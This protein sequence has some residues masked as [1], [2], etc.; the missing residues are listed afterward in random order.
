MRTIKTGVLYL[1]DR[2]YRDK[3]GNGNLTDE[4][5]AN[6]VYKDG[7]IPVYIVEALEE[8]YQIDTVKVYAVKPRSLPPMKNFVEK[9]VTKGLV[10]KSVLSRLVNSVA[11]DY[12]DTKTHNLGKQKIEL[13][14]LFIAPT[15][16]G[17]D[18]LTGEFGV[19]FYDRQEDRVVKYSQQE[20]SEHLAI[21]GE[22]LGEERF[23]QGD[24]TGIFITLD[25]IDWTKEVVAKEDIV[26]MFRAEEIVRLGDYA[27]D[28]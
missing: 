6:A 14:P 11:T 18:T 21:T 23:Q 24:F 13:P 8:D 15:Q 26:D 3:L 9:E 19:G 12:V 2:K 1:T 28:L 20:R 5:K 25:S 16:E 27:L 7:R 17:I 22:I 10:P 4:E